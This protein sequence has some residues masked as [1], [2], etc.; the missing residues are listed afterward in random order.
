MCGA[1]HSNAL[2]RIELDGCRRKFRLLAVASKP[3][4]QAI[5]PSASPRRIKQRQ[6]LSFVG[7]CPKGQRRTIQCR[8]IIP[9]SKNWRD[10]RRAKARGVNP[11]VRA[12]ATLQYNHQNYSK[13]QIFSDFHPYVKQNKQIN[14]AR[15]GVF[16][17]LICPLFIFAGGHLM[18]SRRPR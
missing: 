15:R 10:A 5:L 17:A 16:G 14:S 4:S 8:E 6:D 3:R 18:R 11:G 7:S 1:D 13:C 9:T 2:R 12:L